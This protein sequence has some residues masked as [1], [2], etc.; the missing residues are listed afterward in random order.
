MRLKENGGTMNKQL[1][2]LSFVLYWRKKRIFATA[3]EF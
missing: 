2:R 1:D 3:N